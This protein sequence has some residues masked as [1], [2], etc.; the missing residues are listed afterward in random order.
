MI[1]W[2]R[3]IDFINDNKENA[4]VAPKLFKAS[5]PEETSRKALLS[6]VRDIETSGNLHHD[7]LLSSIICILEKDEQLIRRLFET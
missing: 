3:P 1:H 7:W 6:E 4:V 2:R 5:A